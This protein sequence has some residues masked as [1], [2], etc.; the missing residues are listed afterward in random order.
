MTLQHCSYGGRPANILLPSAA[1]VKQGRLGARDWKEP[2]ED[3]SISV[4]PDF[5]FIP[6]TT[7]PLPV[8][9]HWRRSEK[10]VV[11]S[12][13]LWVFHSQAVIPSICPKAYG[14][15]SFART[16]PLH[17]I[18]KSRFLIFL[19]D[20]GHQQEVAGHELHAQHIAHL[21]GVDAQELSG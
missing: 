12:G 15:V 2:Q 4:F 11:G 3:S 1:P 7:L 21:V 13:H 5:M 17:Q 19:C 9:P 6:I 16:S 20:S 10:R 14:L 18:Y 8:L